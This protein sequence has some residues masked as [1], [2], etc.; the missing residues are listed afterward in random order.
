MW[1]VYWHRTRSEAYK[2]EGE[3][4]CVQMVCSGK[5]HQVRGL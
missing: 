5:D 4:L 1:F 2:A 3:G